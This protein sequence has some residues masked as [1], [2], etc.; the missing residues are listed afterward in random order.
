MALTTIRTNKDPIEFLK[1]EFS[2]FDMSVT[3]GGIHYRTELGS[4]YYTPKEGVLGPKDFGMIS[5]VK[6]NADWLIKNTHI[7]M[8]EI[9]PK[10]VD[11]SEFSKD[12]TMINKCYEIDL[13]AAYW[14]I[15]HAYGLTDERVF[16]EYMVSNSKKKLARNMSIG[17]LAT[18]TEYFR[19]EEGNIVH[20]D[21]VRRPTYPI[22]WN[23][24]KMCDDVLQ[25]AEVLSGDTFLFYWIDAIFILGNNK[26]KKM[27]CDLFGDSGFEFKIRNIHKVVRCGRN[28]YIWDDKEKRKFS[29]PEKIDIHEQYKLRR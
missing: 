21:S 16:A 20:K 18:K 23:V 19:Y 5:H 6:S 17:S 9:K 1:K 11:I 24:A 27:L 13:K 4:I 22:F 29:I 2:S 10:F 15:A 3:S 12:I 25:N 7:S 28:V 14:K 8:P 26:I